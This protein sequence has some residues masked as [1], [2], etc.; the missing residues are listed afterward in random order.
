V[1]QADLL[2]VAVALHQRRLVVLH[3]LQR[4]GAAQVGT[5][6]SAA[7][8]QPAGEGAPAAAGCAR[9]KH[10]AVAWARIG[11]RWRGWRWRGNSPP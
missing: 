4:R 11:R 3:A 7:Q 8:P 6:R 5:P 2:G 1:H 9:S 10:G